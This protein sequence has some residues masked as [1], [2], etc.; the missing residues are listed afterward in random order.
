MLTLCRDE[1]ALVY[2]EVVDDRVHPSVVHHVVHVP[3][4][5]VVAALSAVRDKTKPLVVETRGRTC[6]CR[7]SGWAHGGSARSRLAHPVMCFLHFRSFRLWM[8]PC[9]GH[10]VRHEAAPVQVPPPCTQCPP[11]V[12][13]APGDHRPR[14]IFAFSQG[15]KINIIWKKTIL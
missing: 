15:I 10:S 6:R 11:T 12:L 9:V 7:P 5:G 3:V 4:P 2:E 1:A 13:A 8:N 14:S